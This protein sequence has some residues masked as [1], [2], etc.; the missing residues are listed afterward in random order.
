[1]DALG[2]REALREFA[3]LVNRLTEEVDDHRRLLR[4]QERQLLSKERIDADVLEPD[5]VDHARGRLDH[6]RHGIAAPGCKRNPLGHDRAER[7]EVVELGELLAV[8]ERP[9][10]DHDGILEAQRTY[11]DACVYHFNSLALNTGPSRHARTCD[12]SARSHMHP[13][14]TPMPQAMYSSIDTCVGT[15]YSWPSSARDSSIP[16][17]PHA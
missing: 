6:A 11:V 14:H 9:R 3:I 1:M 2:N 8:A 13:K 5:R 7:G 15:S 12:P 4:A 16:L 17:G 10:R